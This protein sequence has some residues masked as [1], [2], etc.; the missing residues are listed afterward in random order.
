MNK[1]I[2]VSDNHP[3][4]KNVLGS[5]YPS[6][7][8]DP[9]SINTL[10]GV[11]FDETDL[12]VDLTCFD[13][14]SKMDLYEHLDIVFDGPIVSDLT[15]NWGEYLIG[16]YENVLGAVAAAFYSPK[17]CFEFYMKDD[18]I[19][20][21]A[22]DVFKKLG[23]DLEI[24]NHIGIGFTYPRV[25][26][27]IINEAYFAKEEALASN[28]DIDKAMKFGVNYPLGPFEWAD[29][30]GIEKILIL[31]EELREITGDARYRPSRLLRMN[32]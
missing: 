31:L 20:E 26:S 17:S 8:V 2:L 9:Y 24:V 6:I 28:S 29:K 3:L 10:D 11:D 4:Y 27:Q 23:F 22:F 32:L 12:I 30:I 5:E 15:V 25:I 19:E 18:S 13:R 7:V 16:Q 14:N 21:A 1:T